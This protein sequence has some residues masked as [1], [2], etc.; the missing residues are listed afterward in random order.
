MHK[1]MSVQ[2]FGQQMT[3]QLL[4]RSLLSAPLLEERERY[5]TFKLEGAA[6]VVG[7][8]GLVPFTGPIM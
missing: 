7:G 6:R 3:L 5:L 1:K 2:E 4:E 8:A